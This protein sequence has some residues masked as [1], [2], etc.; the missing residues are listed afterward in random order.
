MPLLLLLSS[1][2]WLS[3]AILEF[4][5]TI[6]DQG[7]VL[8]ELLAQCCI[9]PPILYNVLHLSGW[10]LCY[11][12][13]C[14]YW[15]CPLETGE[16]WL[17]NPTRRGLCPSKRLGSTACPRVPLCCMWGLCAQGA[18]Y[19]QSIDHLSQ[20]LSH[21]LLIDYQIGEYLHE[22]YFWVHEGLT[23]ALWSLV[24]IS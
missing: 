22:G 1:S 14:C 17:G 3:R 6:L 8:M 24:S 2:L 5:S 19:G 10:H 16:Q 18:H 11:R 20:G 4:E 13:L 7:H 12:L 21:G 23:T 15:R 9:L